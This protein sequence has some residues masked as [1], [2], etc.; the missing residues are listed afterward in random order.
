MRCELLGIKGTWNEILNSAR[1]TVGKSEIERS[2][3]STW[4]KQ[5]LLAE[6]SPIRQ[7]TVKA[8]WHDLKSWVSV[9]LVR[10]WLGIIHW[11][12]SQRDDRNNSE[13]SR[14]DKPQSTLIEHEIEANAQAI[15]NISRKRLCTCASSETREAWKSFLLTFKDTE[16]ELYSV[17]VPECVYRGFCPELHS[18]GLVNSDL[19]PLL[20][21]RYRKVCVCSA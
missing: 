21:E 16:P 2:P 1:T 9:H 13:V 20:L 15:I 10:H 12:K 19:Y 14:D 17:C 11:V 5:L 3:S 8:K 7:L 18:C 6:H 4:K